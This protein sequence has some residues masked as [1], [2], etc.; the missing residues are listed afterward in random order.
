MMHSIVSSQQQQPVEHGINKTPARNGTRRA[1]GDIS[2]R[3]TSI[4]AAPF[5][6]VNVSKTPKPMTTITSKYTEPSKYVP[7]SGGKQEI[8]R[9][10]GTTTL[11]RPHH[12]PQ[13]SLRSTTKRNQTN[14]V[15]FILPQ[16]DTKKTLT[17][18]APVIPSQQ[19]QHRSSSDTHAQN[20]TNNHSS[21]WNYNDES[22]IEFPAGRLYQEQLLLYD[23]DDNDSA[24]QLSIE[25][26]KTFR[27][28]FRNLFMK[29]HN[30]EMQEKEKYIQ[31]C[32]Q[33]L[34][35]N[36]IITDDDTFHGDDEYDQ[37]TLDGSFRADRYSIGDD[38]ESSTLDEE[39]YFSSKY[40]DFPPP[41]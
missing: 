10:T 36:C 30:E 9:N 16:Q 33:Q 32:T 21:L 4:A 18:H 5:N 39:R 13:P 40:I 22:E 31:Y 37:S 7:A 29:Q 23:D 20:D 17:H 12:H 1:L 28:D 41:V 8:L 15:K 11:E 27:D 14:N 35:H 34:E 19:Q 38:R 25:G 6:N 26:A 24:S 3:K 2:N